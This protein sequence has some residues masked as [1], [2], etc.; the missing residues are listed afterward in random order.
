MTLLILFSS[1][2]SSFSIC[3]TSTCK[4]FLLFTCCKSSRVR[5]IAGQNCSGLSSAFEALVIST[6]ASARMSLYF[7]GTKIA[8]CD[9]KSPERII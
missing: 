5:T 3:S 6:R 9:F 7:C 2:A 1:T 8:Y 4:T